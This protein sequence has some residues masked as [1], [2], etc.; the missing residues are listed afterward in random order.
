MGDLA[1]LGL[2]SLPV[3]KP[4][5]PPLNLKVGVVA[6]TIGAVEALTILSSI[7]FCWGFDCTDPLG[8]EAPEGPAYLYDRCR[9]NHV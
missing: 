1:S 5:Q 8:A 4:S 3:K 2:Q 9:G 6:R 7:Q